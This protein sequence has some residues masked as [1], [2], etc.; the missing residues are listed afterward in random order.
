M[1]ETQAQFYSISRSCFPAFLID[2]FAS[3]S[4]K[5][6]ESQ[7]GGA[8]EPVADGEPFWRIRRQGDDDAIHAGVVESVENGV[9]AGGVVHRLS[10]HDHA[11]GNRK[12]LLGCRAETQPADPPACSAMCG[13]EFPSIVL[14]QFQPS[15]RRVVASKHAGAR[16]REARKR[17]LSL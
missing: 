7:S 10:G 12:S 1:Q 13:D 3:C 14:G 17:G 6:C 16:N 11:P 8:A 15:P 9:K 2:C 5:R 4:R